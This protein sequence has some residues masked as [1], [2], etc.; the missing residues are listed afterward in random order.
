[1][2][3]FTPVQSLI[4]GMIIG[5]AAVLLMALHGRI[6][7]ITGI[8]GGLLPPRMDR[9]W[10]WRLAM[11][12]GM[13]AAPLPYAF[14]RLDGLA[15]ISAPIPFAPVASLPMT[16]LGGIIVGIGVTYGA[17]CTSGHGVCGLARFSPR[18]L[19][20]VVTFMFSTAATVFYVRHLAG[21]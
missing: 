2:T 15:V 17:G 9:D 7:G 20:A 14:L 11:L 21:A 3:E 12:A 13:V 16:V 8:L 5:A 1:M 10:A 4:G 18:S 6:A 19:A